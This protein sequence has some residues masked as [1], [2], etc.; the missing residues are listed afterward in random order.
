[1]TA[2]DADTLVDVFEIVQH[3]RLRHQLEQLE[4][5]ETPSDTM[6]LRVM[7]TIE[8]SVLGE[9]N[10]EIVAIQ[11]RMATR[12]PGALRNPS[13]HRVTARGRPRWG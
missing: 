13:R 10:R 1:M 5:V 6:R 2:E 3:V 12:E 9:A 11:R 4:A 7:S 8:A